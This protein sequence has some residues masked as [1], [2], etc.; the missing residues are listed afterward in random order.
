[1]ETTLE[2]RTCDKCQ[3]LVPCYQ[4]VC[5]SCPPPVINLHGGIPT[6]GL[7]SQIV[8]ALETHGQVLVRGS[9]I[10]YN[11]GSNLLYMGALIANL[12]LPEAGKK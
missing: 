4:T 1:M 2:D 3:A 9:A 6:M 8:V 11:P 7:F 10:S 12:G 5:Q